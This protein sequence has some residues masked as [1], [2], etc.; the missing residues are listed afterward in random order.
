MRRRYRLP[1]FPKKKLTNSCRLR[2]TGRVSENITQTQ[3]RGLVGL[4]LNL[5]IAG[6][7]SQA[8]DLVHL[9]RA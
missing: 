5:P 7:V 1:P 3:P 4:A 6:S 2:G 8:D 9:I